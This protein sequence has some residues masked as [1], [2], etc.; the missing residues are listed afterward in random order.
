MTLK[1][2]PTTL[3]ITV[4]EAKAHCRID[5]AD[6][7]MM[8]QAIIAAALASI[9][10]PYGRGLALM[11][12]SWVLTL[13]SWYG[14]RYE[15]WWTQYKMYDQVA[16][17]PVRIPL[18]PVQSVTAVKYVDPAGVEQT[19]DPSVYRVD[20][21]QQPARVSP[22]F[23]QIWPVHRFIP[24][25]ISIEFKAGFADEANKLPADLV[26]A[27]KLLIKHFYDNREAVLVT[28]RESRGVIELPWGVESIISRY[29]PAAVA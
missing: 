17:V 6:D 20:V 14:H 16:R 19:L 23:G 9:E 7:D 26:A 29:A 27:L 13:D 5:Y 10:G 22:E 28:S 24:A 4:D 15:T 8:M 11:T 12:Q 21:S 1:T 25:P 3:P 2:A 18:F